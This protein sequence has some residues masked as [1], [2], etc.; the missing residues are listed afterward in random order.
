MNDKLFFSVTITMTQ[1]ARHYTLKLYILTIICVNHVPF[2][3]RPPG[4]SS[5]PVRSLHDAS[6]ITL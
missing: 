3:S 2:L 5:M 6:D 1:L 4:L